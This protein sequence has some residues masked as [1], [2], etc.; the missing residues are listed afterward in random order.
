MLF[1]SRD[2]KGGIFGVDINTEF[3]F[4]VNGKELGGESEMKV[5]I[6]F[7]VELIRGLVYYL[8]K[9]VLDSF[10]SVKSSEETDRLLLIHHIKE[11]IL[12][13]DT[14]ENSFGLTRNQIDVLS[15]LLSK[16]IRELKGIGLDDIETNSDIEKYYNSKKLLFELEMALEFIRESDYKQAIQSKELG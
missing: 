10:S 1:K 13:Y 4:K 3:D 2:K 5:T 6:I 12:C 16:S 14:M 7:P 8:G 11:S 15:E 9:C